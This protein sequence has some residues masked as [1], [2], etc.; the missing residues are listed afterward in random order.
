MLKH[1]LGAFRILWH[2]V[3]PF[4]RA[5]SH[6]SPFSSRELVYNICAVLHLR[7]SSGSLQQRWSRSSCYWHQL[8]IW[9]KGDVLR[10]YLTC[11]LTV[12][13]I[14]LRRTSN[15]QWIIQKSFSYNIKYRVLNLSNLTSLIVVHRANKQT[16]KTQQFQ[17][18]KLWRVV[19]FVLS[20]WSVV[21]LPFLTLSKDLC[22]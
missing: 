19:R 4:V 17:L 2:F 6:L 3:W 1:I 12:F 16:H 11:S 13:H 22:Q 15:F 14:F 21:I 9:V 5:S 10:S 7:A 20:F 18:Y 8:P